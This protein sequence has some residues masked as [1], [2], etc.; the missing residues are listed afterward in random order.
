MLAAMGVSNQMCRRRGVLRFYLRI[1][2]KKEAALPDSLIVHIT[3]S[4]CLPSP[5][6]IS[7]NFFV[8]TKPSVSKR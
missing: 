6:F 5:Y 7:V 1:I 4:A 2:A 3:W 8:A